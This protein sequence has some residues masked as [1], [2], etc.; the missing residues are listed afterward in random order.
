MG[1]LCELEVWWKFMEVKAFESNVLESTASG[2]NMPWCFYFFI[3]VSAKW[4]WVC[5]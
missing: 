5:I 3:A 2:N 1:L 4:I